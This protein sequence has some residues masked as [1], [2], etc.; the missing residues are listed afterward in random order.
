ML[1]TSC[2]TSRT[3]KRLPGQSMT[4]CCRGAKQRWVSKYLQSGVLKQCWSSCDTHLALSGAGISWK[5]RNV[6]NVAVLP[7]VPKWARRHVFLNM[8][9]CI[10]MWWS[11]HT[12]VPVNSTKNPAYHILSYTSALFLNILITA[13][14]LFRIFCR[15]T[16]SWIFKGP[17]FTC[18][19]DRLGLGK[20]GFLSWKMPSFSKLHRFEV[21]VALW[22]SASLR[23]R[24]NG[25]CQWRSCSS[26]NWISV[27]NFK[28]NHQV[29]QL[30]DF[31]W[32]IPFCLVVR[33]E[34]RNCVWSLAKIW[35]NWISML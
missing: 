20:L 13:T 7:K 21:S 34:G 24:D 4:T 32:M 33:L 5:D 28:R 35:T 14:A 3:I 23:P 8:H 16:C 18:S 22:A 25:P 12:T 10:W 15:S 30:L 29:C 1:V 27:A 26:Q 2:N 19:S 17:G 11:W 6:S 9:E 31:V